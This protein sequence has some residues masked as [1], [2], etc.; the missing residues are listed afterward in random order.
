ML[1]FSHILFL[2]VYYVHLKILTWYF[3][4][5]WNCL[6]SVD[7]HTIMSNVLY[8]AYNSKLK[9]QIT[10][11]NTRNMHRNKS[12]VQFMFQN[13]SYM[14]L[15]Y[16]YIFPLAISNSFQTELTRKNAESLNKTY[17]INHPLRKR[18]C[19]ITDRIN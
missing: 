13:E 5:K 18:Y 19:L 4:Y 11:V 10:L 7:K 12:R 8:L 2:R 15:H 16:T 14:Y 3:L 17:C 9:I 1:G 6:I